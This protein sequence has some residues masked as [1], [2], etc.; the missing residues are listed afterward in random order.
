MLQNAISAKAAMNPPFWSK[1]FSTEIHFA[2]A[3]V[4][5]SE[6]G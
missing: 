3:N 5:L 6:E 4:V 1:N 2:R